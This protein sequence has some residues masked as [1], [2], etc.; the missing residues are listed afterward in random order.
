MNSTQRALTAFFF[1][2]SLTVFGVASAQVGD[3]FGGRNYGSEVPA[4][5]AD[6]ASGVRGSLGVSLE[7]FSLSNNLGKVVFLLNGGFALLAGGFAF[8][9]VARHHRDPVR[10]WTT[11]GGGELEG[12]L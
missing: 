6:A 1:A 9:T 12:Q 4:V 7:D 5:E 3:S 8:F 11:A 2:V 10:P